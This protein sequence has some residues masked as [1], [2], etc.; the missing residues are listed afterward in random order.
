MLKPTVAIVV[1]AGMLSC[2]PAGSENARETPAATRSEVSLRPAAAKQILDDVRARRAP[3]VLVNVWATW[4]LPCREE[5]PDLMRLR[6]TFAKQGLELVLVSADFEEQIPEA[7][8]FLAENGVDFPTYVKQQDDM[9]FINAMNPD[10]SGAL[11]A[12]FVFDRGG[13]LRFFHEGK[14]D[15]AMLAEPIREVLAADA[16]GANQEE[17]P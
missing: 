1:L 5:F 9:A 6:Q 13:E 3:A 16:A 14:A 2:T 17:T 11:P 7:K 15:T 10:W 12:S 4:C 8:A